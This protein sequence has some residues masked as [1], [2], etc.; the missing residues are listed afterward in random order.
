MNC[1]LVILQN[2]ELKRIMTVTILI[3]R[4]NYRKFILISCFKCTIVE[5]ITVLFVE[6]SFFINSPLNSNSNSFPQYTA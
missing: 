6:S 2:N 1:L 5:D 3:K 4:K